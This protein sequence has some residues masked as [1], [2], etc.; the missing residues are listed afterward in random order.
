MIGRMSDDDCAGEDIH[1][2]QNE[3]TDEVIA[4]ISAMPVLRR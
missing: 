4:R 2:L 1:A 3:L